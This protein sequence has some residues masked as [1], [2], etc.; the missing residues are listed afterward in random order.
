MRKINA[1]IASLTLAGLGQVVYQDSIASPICEEGVCEVVFENTDSPQSFSVPPGLAELEF[2]VYG[3]QGGSGGGLGGYVSGVLTDLPETITVMVGGAGLTGD[4]VAGGFNGGGVA[5]GGVGSPGSGGGASDIRFGNNLIDRVVV[6]GGGGGRGGPLGGYGGDGGGEVATSGS[7]GQGVG[8]AGGSQTVGGAGGSTNSSGGIDGA[9]G[10]LG[11]G[12]AGGYDKS[13]YGGG[14]GGGGYYGGGGGGAD[15]DSCCT[16]AGGGG[17]GSSFADSTYASSLSFQAGTRRDGG[18]VVL[19]YQKPAE[20]TEFSYQQLTP[21]SAS[22]TLSFD[23]EVASVDLSDFVI[24]GCE[25]ASL[26]SEAESHLLSLDGCNSNPTVE[27]ASGT[28]GENQNLPATNQSLSLQLDQVAP[29][30]QLHAPEATAESSFEV[31]IETDETGIFDFQNIVVADC[32]FVSAVEGTV[33]TLSFSECLEGENL[34]TLPIDLLTDEIGNQSLTTP[35][36]ISVLIDQTAPGLSF[37]ETSFEETEQPNAEI[38]STTPVVFG[39]VPATFEQFIFDGHESCIVSSEETEQG[40]LLTTQGCSAGEAS[41]TM[42]AESMQDSVGNQGP[43]ESIVAQFMIPEITVVEA[44]PEPA[45]EPTPEETVEPNPEP[46]PVPDPEPTPV[47]ESTEESTSVPTPVPDTTEP[48]PE[49]NPVPVI[50]PEPEPETETEPEPEPEP[51]TGQEPSQGSEDEIIV[52]SESTPE[53]VIETQAEEE[54]EVENQSLTE[55]DQEITA[56]AKGQESNQDSIP[57]VVDDRLPPETLAVS[58][59]GNNQAAAEG[60]QESIHPWAIAI[61]G[62]LVLALLI[63]VLVLTKN[64]RPRA[65][66]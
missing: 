62:L 12:G 48:T 18:L 6:A 31:E 25:V 27:I 22:V 44:E 55:Q 19:R 47:P 63:A 37:E 30:F 51:E 34:I 11:L 46:E 49:V 4:R 13:G 65:I 64:N 59:A 40:M 26:D 41:W 60:D 50:T 32:D 39:E 52:E 28:M 54:I 17:G 57:S 3:A 23:S 35:R 14:A 33:A 43:Q 2:E 66:D 38:I 53:P 21:A 15:T 29:A 56:E 24:T 45:P 8:G 58:E 1:I 9:S 36:E 61:A 5:G 7:S 16:D 20:I 10:E 42:P